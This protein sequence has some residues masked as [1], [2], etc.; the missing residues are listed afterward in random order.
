MFNDDRTISEYEEIR[1]NEKERRLTRHWEIIQRFHT[2]QEDHEW[3]EFDSF[4]SDWL[5]AMFELDK[6]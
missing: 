2:K 3:D 4:Q 1:A 5:N 6:V